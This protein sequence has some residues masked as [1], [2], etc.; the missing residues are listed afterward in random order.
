VGAVIVDQ[1]RRIVSTGYNGLP[2]G[3]EDSEERLNNRDLKYKMIV[4]GERNALLFAQRSVKDCVLYTWP[5]MPCAAC[6]SMV[7]QSGI[8]RVVAPISDN[9]RW[10]EEFKLS[11]QL[12]NEAGVELVLIAE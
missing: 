1:E 4:H 11:E 10:A 6:A 2:R 8:N 9:P 12:F 7:I 5:F 3:V